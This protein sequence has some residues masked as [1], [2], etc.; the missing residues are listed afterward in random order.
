M[1]FRKRLLIVALAG[2]LFGHLIVKAERYFTRARPTSIIE[3]PAPVHW[4]D[5]GYIL[6]AHKPTLPPRPP[7][8]CPP[9]CKTEWPY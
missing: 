6:L 7:R 5:E 2:M 3:R 8:P 4:S 9:D 1:G